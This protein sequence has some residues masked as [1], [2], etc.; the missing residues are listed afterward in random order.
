MMETSAGIKQILKI[1]KIPKKLLSN[2]VLV[3]VDNLLE[4]GHVFKTES[5]LEIILAGGEYEETTRITRY[6]T[7]AKVPEHLWLRNKDNH[8]GMEWK[9]DM[10]LEVGDLV[11]FGI[12]SSANAI[13]V[14]IS[15]C[16]DP[17]SH[18]TYF[19]LD[20]REILMR[21]RKGVIRPLNGFV[22]MKKIMEDTVKISGLVLDFVKQRNKN[23]GVIT[24]VGEPNEYYLGVGGIDDYAEDADVVVG[25]VV[26]LS[27][28]AVTPL[29]DNTFAEMDEYYYCQRRW[30]KAVE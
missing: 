7:V 26:S 5:G 16:D 25:D 14:H 2:L 8:N 4:D 20:Y 22:L 12:M 11:Y 19:L 24:H 29:E 6:G 28:P 23:K 30:I 15:A 27:I 10:E 17:T 3:R 18:I 21:I 9:T 13:E 1:D